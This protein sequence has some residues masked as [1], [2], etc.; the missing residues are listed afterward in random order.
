M[1]NINSIINK[2]NTIKL[3]ITKPLNVRINFYLLRTFPP[4]SW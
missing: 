1:P 4:S 2:S 3:N